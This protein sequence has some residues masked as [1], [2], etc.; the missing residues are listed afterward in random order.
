MTDTVTQFTKTLREEIGALFGVRWDSVLEW[1]IIAW[2][3]AWFW[4][5][6]VAALAPKESP[7]KRLASDADGNSGPVSGIGRF[8]QFV[9]ISIPGWLSGFVDW[10]HEPLNNWIC[11]AATLL[12]VA[13]CVTAVRSYRHTGLRVIALTSAAIAC[14]I[15]GN[16]APVTWILFLSAIP[17]IWACSLDWI[18]QRREESKFSEDSYYF[19]QGILTKFIS[20]IIFLFIQVPAAPALIIMQLIVSFRTDLRYSPSVELNREIL[21]VLKTQSERDETRLDALTQRASSAV[22]SLTGSQSP[23]AQEILRD[24]HRAL[25]QRREAMESA[26][27]RQEITRSR[28]TEIRYREQRNH[29]QKGQSNDFSE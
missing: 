12:A 22:D 14:E 17:T 29:I 7:L 10:L 3:S 13:T 1:I 8:I 4:L 16:L 18:D 11:V 23:D 27:R 25:Q 28:A 21:K 9:D 5:Q 26:E 6:S 15:N 2:L 19:A 24:Y 20:R